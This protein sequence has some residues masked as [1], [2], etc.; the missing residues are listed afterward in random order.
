MLIYIST[1]C[2]KV[3][4]ADENE[5]ANEKFDTRLLGNIQSIYNYNFF[6]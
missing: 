4:F 1:L 6:F 3:H 5:K 2:V